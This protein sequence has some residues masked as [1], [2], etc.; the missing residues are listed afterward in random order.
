MKPSFYITTPIYYVNDLPH[1]GH[2]YSTLVADVMARAERLARGASSVFFLTGTDEHGAKIAEKATAAGLSPQAFADL[3]AEKFKSAWA[4]LN[5]QYD[6]FIRTTENRHSEAVI[7]IMG[8]LRAAQTPAGRDVLYQA[9]YEGLYCVGCEKFLTAKDIVDGKCPLHDREPELVKEKNWFF[10]LRDYLPAL[11]EKI[12]N[13][14][15]VI[16]PEE[17]K[18]ETLG[19][20]KQGLED[21]SVSRQKVKW[22]IPVPWDQEQ[23]IYVWLEALMNYITGIGYPEDKKKFSQWWPANIQILGPDIL[24]FHAI[25]WPVMLL[26]LDLPLPEKLYVHG[27][28][29][30]DGK[31]MSK[32]LGNAIDPIALTEKYGADAARYLILSQF[33]FGFES[34]IKVTDFDQRYTAQLVNGLSNLVARLTNLAEK[35]LP[36]D[37]KIELVQDESQGKVLNLIQAAKFKEALDFCWQII[38]QCDQELEQTKPWEMAKENPQQAAEILIKLLGQLRLVGALLEPLMPQTS[39]II[40]N[41]FSADSI[42]R[43]ANIF[44]RLT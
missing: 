5:I 9:D 44:N 38:S 15:L 6:D 14:S 33:A 26:A 40:T 28:F 8:R 3:N 7:K 34:D 27:Y 19:L 18:N 30:V 39:Q 32:S 23:V 42:K 25:Y 11:E 36:V 4:A 22:G 16:Y 2:A 24:K 41:I 29:T 43:P 12:N 10:R 31:K 20:F 37:I 13:G 21:F 1:L 35:H 17:R